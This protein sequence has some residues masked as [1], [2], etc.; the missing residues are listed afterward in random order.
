MYFFCAT[1]LL[2]V[3]TLSV[4]LMEID[5]N[6]TFVW[7]NCLCYNHV[8]VNWINNYNYIL[9]FY[10]IRIPSLIRMGTRQMKTIF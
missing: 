7:C 4:Q 1:P 2:V 3:V 9:R 6:I 8:N 10:F 5:L